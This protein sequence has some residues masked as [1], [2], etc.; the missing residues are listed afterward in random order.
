MPRKPKVV[1][2][3][4]DIPDDVMAAMTARAAELAEPDDRRSLEEL[5]L[6]LVPLAQKLRATI[7]DIALIP[8]ARATPA[9]RTEL[10][11]LRAEIDRARSDLSTWQDAIDMSFRRA[12]IE[13]GA[14]E[15]P[16]TDGIVKIEQQRGEWVVN[17]P[18]LRDELREFVRAGVITQPEFDA[19]FT[20]VVTEKADNT[21]LNA[22]AKHRGGEV[23]DAV[24][25]GRSWKP[26]D[27][28]SAKV[29][30]QR[31]GPK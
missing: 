29:R 20:T 27:P 9:Q 8:I 19:I 24:D 4:L 13:S 16:L 25:R 30:I 31:G 6:E 10:V 2:P 22:I 15:F 14:D 28:A 23:A 21:K 11:A 3:G 5:R 18:A 17:V 1:T 26:G 7:A 12:A